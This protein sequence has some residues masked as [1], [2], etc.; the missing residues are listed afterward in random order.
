MVRERCA[1]AEAVRKSSKEENYKEKPE[2]TLVQQVTGPRIASTPPRLA[3]VAIQ[4]PCLPPCADS[5][6]RL[7]VVRLDGGGFV[8]VPYCARCAGKAATVW[9]REYGAEV[10][11]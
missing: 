3:I 2:E 7:A 8:A 11:Q 5:C 9:S 4:N 6:G 10:R 1:R